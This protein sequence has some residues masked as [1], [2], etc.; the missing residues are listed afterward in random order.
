MTLLVEYRLHPLDINQSNAAAASTSPTS[1]TP[2]GSVIAL[3]VT[4]DT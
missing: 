4:T 2:K 3:E 1:T